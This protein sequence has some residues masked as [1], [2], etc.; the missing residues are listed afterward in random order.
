MRIYNNGEATTY[1]LLEELPRGS[2]GPAWR[3]RQIGPDGRSLDVAVKVLDPDSWLGQ[4][5][6]PEQMLR[7]WRGQMQVM[8]NFG[9]RGFA[10]V[11][12]AF[13]VS[14]DPDDPAATPDWM[15]GV[16]AFV[17]AWID[18]VRLC[19]WT[20]GVADPVNR[21]TALEVCADG[22]DEF[23]RV[24]GH[25]HRDLKPSNIMVQNNVARIIDYGLIRSLDRLRS[26]SALGGSVPYMDPALFDGAEYSAATDLF[27]FAGI[28]LFQLTLAHPVPGR[29]APE[30]QGDLIRAGFE[31][32][33][34]LI[35]YSLS[36][37]P[38]YRPE[39]DGASGLLARAIALAHPPSRERALSRTVPGPS[40]STTVQLQPPADGEDLRRLILL[41]I[42]LPVVIAGA[43]TVVAVVIL[44]ALSV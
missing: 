2:E 10:P 9:H 12:V 19:D 25:V 34:S 20:P 17:M 13:A 21:L 43:L 8:R 4:Q 33:A 36:P 42:V 35:G 16:P 38:A 18:G 14:E 23:H 30:V 15:I 27:S 5:V 28:L 7:T 39:V 31:P 29:L 22:L 24:T 1:E 26:Q 11:Q 40:D 32:L 3:A 44:R 41:K 37:K 6:D